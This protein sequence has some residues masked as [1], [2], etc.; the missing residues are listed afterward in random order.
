[1]N[2]T[3]STIRQEVLEYIATLPKGK[4]TTYKILAGRFQTHPR[5]IAAIMKYNQDPIKYPCYKVIAHSGKISGYNTKSWVPEKIKKLQK[6]G[7]EIMW[8]VI[9]KKYIFDETR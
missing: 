7:V 1:M 9:P 3:L 2:Q 6:D 8:G 5:T 4:V